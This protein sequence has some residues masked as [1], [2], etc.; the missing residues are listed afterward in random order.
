[1]TKGVTTKSFL[2]KSFLRTKSNSEERSRRNE[3]YGS[4]PAS[5]LL[6]TS[7]A[8]TPFLVS[9]AITSSRRKAG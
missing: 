3:V 2:R 6:T 5:C 1:M 8:M 9:P 4:L 7:V